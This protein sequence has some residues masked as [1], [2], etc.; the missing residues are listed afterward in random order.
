MDKAPVVLPLSRPITLADGSTLSELTLHEPSAID[1]RSMPVGGELNVGMLLDLAANVAGVPAS[2]LNQ[3]SA[4]DVMGVV[5]AMGK[6]MGGG[7]GV[8]Q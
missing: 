6:F 1:M 5:A 4:S 2:A 8:K 3:L 7:T